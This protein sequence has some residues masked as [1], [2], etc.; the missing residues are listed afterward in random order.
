MLKSRCNGRGFQAAF[1][2][3]RRAVERKV[4]RQRV[5]LGR[6]DSGPGR[7]EGKHLGETHD[8]AAKG[9]VMA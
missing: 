5:G 9:A 7:G 3:R 4:Q 8:M 6:S 1:S 2:R